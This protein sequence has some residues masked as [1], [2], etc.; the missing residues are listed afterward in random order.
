MAHGH[1]QSKHSGHTPEVHEHVDSWHHHD[2]SEG[3][4]Q[5]E[6][7]AVL[8]TAALLKWFLLILVLLVLSIG[9][10]WQYFN[11][12]S[13][14]FVAERRETDVLSADYYAHRAATDSE[15]ANYSVTDA[16]AGKVQVP[17]EEAMKKIVGRYQK[18]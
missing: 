14:K 4:P 9:A 16:K 15:L 12:Y 6:H 10:L 7:A 18:K 13:A 8:D 2:R 5:A 3:V 11:F 17:V 1:T